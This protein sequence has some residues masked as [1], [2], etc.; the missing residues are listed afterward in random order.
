[1]N[2]LIISFFIL[3]SLF[4]RLDRL[5]LKQNGSFSEKFIVPDWSKC[6]QYATT[7]PQNVEAI[8]NQPFRYLTK[9][10]QSFVFLSDDGKWVLKFLRLPKFFMRYSY[11]G[12]SSSSPNFTHA[13]DSFK[14]A[15][16]ALSRETAV[17]YSH[18]QPTSFLQPTTLIDHFGVGHQCNFNDLPFLIQKYGDPFFTAFEKSKEPKALIQKTIALYESLFEKG[19]IDHDPI[20]DQN[21]GI[22]DGEPFI[23]DIGQ[24]E[25]TSSLPR[26]ELFLHEMTKSLG[27]KLERESPLLYDYYKKFLQ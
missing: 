4:F 17:I 22:I 2:Y 16:E 26:K 27:S 23:M 24:L 1:M 20:F 18:L 15:Q 5:F 11:K 8:L 6:P 13:V 7:P 9:G 10:R 14:W 21:F 19:F 25:K 12:S 3:S